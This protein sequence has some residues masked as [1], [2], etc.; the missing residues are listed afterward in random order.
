MNLYD[1]GSL[2]DKLSFVS[3][4]PGNIVTKFKTV[5]L[6]HRSFLLKLIVRLGLKRFLENFTTPLVEAVGGYRNHI[7]GLSNSSLEKAGILK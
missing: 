1:K 4:L 7:S 2:M 3:S 5:R 6:Y